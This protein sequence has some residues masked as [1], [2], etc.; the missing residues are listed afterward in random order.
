[1]KTLTIKTFTSTL[2]LMAGLSVHPVL[3]ENAKPGKYTIDPAHTSILFDVNHLGV[4]TLTGRFNT[5]EGEIDLN[6]KGKSTLNVTIE[7]KSVDTNHEKRDVHLRSPDFF[8]VK[9]F[10]K[11]RFVSN[12][13]TFNAKGEPTS[14][15]GKLSLHGKTNPVTLDITSV[16]A[17]KDPWGGYRAGYKGTATIQRSKYGMDFM[18]GGVGDDIHLTLNIEAIK[19]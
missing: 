16:G 19:K 1:M 13:V 18:K 4:S 17:A 15:V 2:V 9:Q 10:P 3:A 12:K 11:M 8:N 7:T 5:F 6:P 14:V